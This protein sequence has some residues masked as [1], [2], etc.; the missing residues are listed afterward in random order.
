[1]QTDVMKENINSLSLT[2]NYLI[3]SQPGDV[4]VVADSAG[5]RT[6]RHHPR[7][8]HCNLRTSILRAAAA[9]AAAATTGCGC[10]GL[11]KKRLNFFNF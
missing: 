6:A 11:R 1:M 2:E 9:A 3:S 10:C 8:S 5:L 4:R 7:A